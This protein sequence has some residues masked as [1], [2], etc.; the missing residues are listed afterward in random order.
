MYLNLIFLILFL[1]VVN[2]APEASADYWAYGPQE[3]LFQGLLSYC[4]FLAYLYLQNS[5][6][7][8]K[9]PSAR[10][11]LGPVAQ[12]QI[13]GFFLIY[14]FLLV[15]QRVY[16]P[17]PSMALYSLISIALY[18]IALGVHHASTY[19][20]HRLF[21]RKQTRLHFS[22]TQLRFLM[23]FVLPFLTFELVFDL[24]GAIPYQPLQD[25][26]AH[27]GDPLM[28]TVLIMGITLLFLVLMLVFMP[29]VIQ[30]LWGC[31][32][33]PDTQL[34]ARLEAL[35]DRAKFKHGGIK[36]WTILRNSH[37]AAIIGIVPR[38]RYV[39]FTD[40]L[41]QR[42]TTEEVEAVLAHEIG[43]S[44]RKHLLWYPL[45]ISG[46]IVCSG[47]FSLLLLDPMF[48]N[49]ALREQLGNAAFWQALRPFALFIPYAAIAVLYFRLV[50][51]LFSRNFERQADLHPLHL[52]L[53]AQDM[54][55]AL[56]SVAIASG[57][58]PNKP[59]WHHYSIQERIRYLQRAEA[60]PSLPP[61]HHRRVRR[62][63][64]GYLVILAIG[65]TA[66]ASP[67]LPDLPGT[68]QLGSVMS[69][70]KNSIS[71]S[72][73]GGLKAQVI[74]QLMTT[75]NLPGDQG[76]IHEALDRAFDTPVAIYLPGIAELIAAE[77]LSLQGEHRASLLLL[78]HAW[79]RFD[80]QGVDVDVVDEFHGLTNK[81]TEA[82]GDSENYRQE[83]RFLLDSVDQTLKRMET[84]RESTQET[85][86]D[87]TNQLLRTSLQLLRYS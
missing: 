42:L 40:G 43:H 21:Y 1:L 75:Y 49:L 73:N 13:L 44:Y 82:A 11:I 34:L 69:S 25:L 79:Q 18:F 48:E 30:K 83:M 14:H 6:I 31:T 72:L 32:P 33:L 74:G 71:A 85:S 26:M 37:T 54:I 9:W 65:A 67:L 84:D 70:L 23:P 22:L 52:G 20:P 53:S 63:L 41:I 81:I 28:E 60:D 39:M 51:G 62:L 68:K 45:I 55:S 19:S 17:P 87:G 4:F 16:A 8:K 5:L 86:Y 58:P 2:L 56:H 76:R 78:G 50:F 29:A 35:C 59:N 7:L 61:K 66:F 57:E 47:L 12:A 77:Q 24:I 3:A 15:S 36:R 64:F 80:F 46:L 27:K 38:F 10:A